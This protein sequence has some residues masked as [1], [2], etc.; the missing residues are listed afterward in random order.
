MRKILSPILLAC[1]ALVLT[2]CAAPGTAST[3]P[4]AS[5]SASPSSQPSAEPP[6]V[7]FAWPDGAEPVVTRKQ[8]GSE[9]RY[10]NPG[11][12]IEHDGQLHMFANLFTAWPGRVQVQHLVSSDGVA[13]TLA[14]PEP[15]IDSQDVPLG[16]LGADVSTGFVADDGTWVLIFETLS[17]IDP[18]VLGRATAPSPD[19]PWTIDPAPI[20]EGG[21][22]GSWDA[23][24][25]S[26][27]SVVRTD[28]GYAMYYT[29]IAQSGGTGVIGLA[30]ST[31]GE[32]WT[33]RDAPVLEAQADWEGGSLDRPRVAVTPAGMV[34]VYAGSDLTDRGVAWSAD[35][36]TWERGG[37][38]PAI[39]QAGFPV[40]GRAWDAALVYRDGALHY[41]LEIGTASGPDGTHIYRAVADLPG[42]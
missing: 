3:R 20:L 41:Y 2:A 21:P 30:E 28:E 19:G 14:Q 24:G 16:G 4:S 34:M 6:S 42:G 7:T 17:S 1:L 18:W 33:K 40:E 27:P 8:A 15:A 23:G 31:D 37:D 32:N 36:T 12:V 25:L 26:W 38:A 35:G 11:A 39:T 29:A 10:I 9:E 5:G 13:W 22:E